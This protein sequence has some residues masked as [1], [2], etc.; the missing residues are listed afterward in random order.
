[1]ILDIEILHC[2]NAWFILGWP[3]FVTLGI[4]QGYF[5]FS[6]DQ[7]VLCWRNL[8]A[9]LNLIWYKKYPIVF[10]LNNN[11]LRLSDIRRND[12]VI[13]TGTNLGYPAIQLKN[14]K[15][16]ESEY[17]WSNT[18]S[19]WVFIMVSKYKSSKKFTSVFENTRSHRSPLKE[20]Y[21][22]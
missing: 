15:M 11:L 1:M 9:S 4:L 12:V 16:K 13:R 20:I 6:N 14:K 17:I 7:G 5:S 19:T 8:V 3:W 2:R 21:L 22:K 18:V 10:S